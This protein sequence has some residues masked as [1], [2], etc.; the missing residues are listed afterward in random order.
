[1]FMRIHKVHQLHK[2]RLARSSKP[3]NARGA[4]VNRC[5]FCQVH[6]DHCICEYQPETTSDAAFLLIMFDTEVLKPSNTGKL[7][8]DVIPETHA[9]LWSRSEP[10]EEMLALLNNEAY[11]PFVVFPEEQIEDKSLV[12]N[13]VIMEE[14]KTPLFIL[15]DGSWREAGRM[16]RKSHIYISYLFFLLRVNNFLITLCVKLQKIISLLLQK[17]PAWCLICLVN[18]RTQDI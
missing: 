1:M 4:N 16:Y 8:A 11:Q 3:F 18:N 15:L 14:G 6:K 12:R 10:S 5:E 13:E 7:I 2:E 17:L 9:Y